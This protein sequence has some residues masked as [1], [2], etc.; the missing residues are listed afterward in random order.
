MGE[1]FRAPQLAEGVAEIEPV[2]RNRLLE[3]F[4]IMGE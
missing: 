4:F 2:R 3:M 1:F